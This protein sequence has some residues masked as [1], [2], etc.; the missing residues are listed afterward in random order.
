MAHKFLTANLILLTILATAARGLS[1]SSD[2]TQP[3][4]AAP[5]PQEAQKIVTKDPEYLKL[6][7]PPQ[8]NAFLQ[9]Y[10]K[11]Y[12]DRSAE[13]EAKV[14]AI[15]D[16]NQRNQARN[17]EWIAAH[18]HDGDKFTFEAEVALREA[19]ISFSERHRDGWFELGRVTYDDNNHV[20]VVLPDS[21][22]PI[23][24]ALRFPMKVSTLSQI[25]AK[26]QE[27]AGPEIER[28]AHEYVAN[29]QAGSNC[30][31]FPDLCLKSTKENLE[32][33]Q[34]AARLE[35]VAQ[36]D[37]E[38]MKIDHLLLV[39]YVTE[40]VLYEL[41]STGSAV[42]SSAWRFSVGP[43]PAAPVEPAT[44]DQQA[45]TSDGGPSVTSGPSG[46]KN[47]PSPTTPANHVSVPA[48]VV[49]AA[50]VTKI[51]PEYPAEARA[52]NIQGDVILHATIDKEGNVSQVQVWS[53]DDALANS[54]VEAVRQWKYK[55]MLVDGEP[56]EVET[57]ITVTFSLKD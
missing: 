53:G 37:L 50:I 42:S 24:A 39:D 52:K 40:A 30:S 4:V 18:Q 17:E 56:K 10:S 2:V 14:A 8:G 34:R 51:N 16:D 36:G 13:I 32:Q 5:T 19:K 31:K 45:G 48:N 23:D 9:M 47:T 49:A 35:M 11:S 54:A 29:A 28:K 6:L 41:S 15:V 46:V 22:T 20:L 38:S 1:Q 12:R 25:Y 43:V 7:N 21:T 55:P 3:A 26:L 57:T 44:A 33:E 27:I